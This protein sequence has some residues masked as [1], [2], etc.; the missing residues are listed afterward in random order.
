MSTLHASSP[1]QALDRL[2]VLA[3]WGSGLPGDVVRRLIAAAVEIVVHLERLPD[4]R[5]VASE[6]A[7]VTGLAPDG[8]QTQTVF[9]FGRRDNAFAWTGI[10]PRLWEKL[11]RA[12]AP[13][14]ALPAPVHAP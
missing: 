7:E 1:V 12:G 2:E 8:V 6:I 11:R 10:P 4:G 5:R 14:P 3:R 13:S 9:R